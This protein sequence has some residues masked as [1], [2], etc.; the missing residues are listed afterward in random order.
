MLGL[1][2]FSEKL[3]IVNTIDKVWMATSQAL[4]G[5]V[6]LIIGFYFGDKNS[7]NSQ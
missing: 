3:G 7:E 1:F 5:I 4:L 6:N 2:I